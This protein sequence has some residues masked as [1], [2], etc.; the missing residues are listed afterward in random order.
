M[1]YYPQIG[2]VSEGTMRDEDLIDTFASELSY[3]M[4]RMRLGRDQRS[5][6]NELLK[7]AR[8]PDAADNCED[9]VG[10]LFDALNEIA[11]PHAYFGALDGDGACYGFWPIVDNDEIPKIAEGDPIGSD[12]WG[13]DVYLVN[14][15]GNVACGYVNKRG[16]FK[17][18]WSVV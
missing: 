6:Y 3:H 4:K 12:W 7:D 1:T 17:P 10:A 14:D 8:E 2:T 18:Y 5:R 13:G 16:V 15:H 11:P 9:I